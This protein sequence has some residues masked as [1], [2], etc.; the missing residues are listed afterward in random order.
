MWVFF[1]CTRVSVEPL[2]VLVS[3]MSKNAILLSVSFS[4]VN[5]MPSVVE[6]IVLKRLSMWCVLMIEGTSST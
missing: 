5:V 1:W 4:I 2:S 3:S 6:L